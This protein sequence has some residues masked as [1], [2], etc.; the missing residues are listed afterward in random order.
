[1]N[2]LICGI[3]IIAKYKTIRDCFFKVC[4]ED[5][6]FFAKNY[7]EDVWVK[8]LFA[9]NVGLLVLFKYVYLNHIK[10]FD[11]RRNNERTTPGSYTAVVGNIKGIEEGSNIG[12]I[13]EDMVEGVKVRKINLVYN[14]SNFYQVI[15]KWIKI[16][17]RLTL[18][19][20][21]ELSSSL[22]YNGLVI[23]RRRLKDSFYRL[24]SEVT[25][26]ENF[27]KLF[28]GFAFVTFDTQKEL[29]MV[30]TKLRY[31]IL[32]FQYQKT[33]YY[34]MPAKE[35][36]DI[37]WQNFGLTLK[38]KIIRRAISITVSI[39]I[40][41]VSFGI[42][43]QIKVAQA[44]LSENNNSESFYYSLSFVSTEII[45]LV[46]LIIRA[47]LRRLTFWESR[48]TTTAYNSILVFKIASAYFCNIALVLL[49]ANLIV[50]EGNLW[51]FG[52]VVGN[53]FIIQAIST[54]S[55]S[56]YEILNPIHLWK[57]GLRKYY[58][59]KI[60]KSYKN[61]RV[62]QVELNSAYEGVKFD[63]AERYYLTFKTISVVFFFQT[64]MPYLLLFGIAELTIIYWT[65]KYVLFKRA[66]RPE[67]L[68]FSFSLKMTRLFDF[69]I[70]ILAFGYFIFEIIIVKIT[71]IFAVLLCSFTLL[72]AILSEGISRLKFFE[73]L[74]KGSDV[75]YEEARKCFAA[76]Y[77]RLNPITQKEAVMEWL[78]TMGNIQI[79]LQS[80]KNIHNAFDDEI[81]SKLFHSLSKYYG[82]AKNTDHITSQMERAI[83]NTE[84]GSP[85]D[86]EYADT[87]VLD[88]NYYKIATDLLNREKSFLYSKI[89]NTK[90]K[91]QQIYHET[92]SHRN[93]LESSHLIIS[94]F[95]VNPLNDSGLPL[96]NHVNEEHNDL[97][98]IE[99]E[100]DDISLS[101]AK[102]E[103]ELNPHLY[104]SLRSGNMLDETDNNSIDSI[105]ILTESKENQE[106]P[107]PD[108]YELKGSKNI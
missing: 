11:L 90:A 79:P 80:I 43:F 99:E 25:K 91:N 18:L 54:V 39:I 8:V 97:E 66:R 44:T 31:K 42:L 69:M 100:K 96:D 89:I 83:R 7:F 78:T 82:K 58:L 76:D 27:S 6:R 75:P 21:K 77:D 13:I 28:T 1:M 61:N 106:N 40:I 29:N 45:I 86:S 36:E 57:K 2:F 4:K 56:L 92:S 64:V 49:I 59:E 105:K 10:G 32:S 34:I 48:T 102:N 16:E 71:S 37:K 3:V 14:I 46:N 84:K 9:V 19:E 85:N 62:L 51:G 108:D 5:S 47:V 95:F 30:L 38:Q 60:R 12:T 41:L 53:I 101:S 65:Q 87:E 23:K 72:A 52:G 74:N 63:I 20:A 94:E 103:N 88:I 33:K 68:D 104:V 67:D 93:I 107:L 98:Q 15:K 17:K 24:K 50:L 55:N 81:H 70:F 35:P 73:R 22:I 26:A